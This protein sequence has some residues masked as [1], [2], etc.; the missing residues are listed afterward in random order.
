MKT[1]T[2]KELRQTAMVVGRMA[3]S[4]FLKGHTEQEA[5]ADIRVE[6]IGLLKKAGAKVEE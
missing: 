5:E 4:H 1:I 3:R 2:D 6:L